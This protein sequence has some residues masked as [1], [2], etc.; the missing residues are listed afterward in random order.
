[1]NNSYNGDITFQ[2]T[3]SWIRHLSRF[4]DGVGKQ[5]ARGHKQEGP[6]QEMVTLHAVVGSGSSGG[7]KTCTCS[8]GPNW[9]I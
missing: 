5:W 1:M 8:V 9:V 4:C 2:L 3:R 7:K 6:G